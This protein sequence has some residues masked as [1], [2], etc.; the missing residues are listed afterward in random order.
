[1]C[2][3]K[4]SFL[5]KKE[6]YILIMRNNQKFYVYK[7]SKNFEEYP[8]CICSKYDDKSLTSSN[9]NQDDENSGGF[10]GFFRRNTKNHDIKDIHAFSQYMGNPFLIDFDI[11]HNKDLIVINREGKIERFHFNKKK[12]GGINPFFSLDWI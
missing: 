6:N 8:K 12:E 1:M 2:I 3:E 5:K 10:F 7:T 9:I 4:L 11:F